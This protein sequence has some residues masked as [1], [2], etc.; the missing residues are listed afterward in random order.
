MGNSAKGAATILTV[1]G[2][3]SSSTFG[4]AI[5]DLWP[6]NHSAT[7]GLT[8]AGS[9]TLVLTGSSSFS[10]PTV[11][12]NGTLRLNGGMYGF[13]GN[14]SGWTLNDS[15]GGNPVTIAGNV[16]TLTTAD[17]SEANAMWYNTPLPVVGSPWTATFTYTNL[18][19]NGA[20]GGA[21]VLQTSGT[22]ALGND[23][24]AKGLNGTNGLYSPLTNSAAIVWNIYSGNGG[25]KVN[26][27]TGGNASP[28]TATGNGVNLDSTAPVNITLAYNGTSA[29]YLTAVQGAN[30]W[31]QT[32]SVALGS[33]LNNPVNGTAY[34]GFVG[35]TGGVDAQ[36]QISNFSFT[37]NGSLGSVLSATSPVQLAA[38]AVLDLNGGYQPVGSL[39]GG[40]TLTNSNAALAATVAVGGDNTS[41]TF[42][43][44]LT[45]AVPGNLALAKIGSGTQTLSGSN[46][47]AG[48]TTVGGGVLRMGNSQALGPAGGSLTISGGT[49]DMNGNSL[50]VS[51]LG[52]I[53]G[54][55]SSSSG[56]A[57]VLTANQASG[58]GT[59]GGVLANGGGTLGFTKTG[60]GMLLL[61]GYNSYSGPTLVSGGTLR[62]YNGASGFGGNGSGWNVNDSTGGYPVSV[63]GDAATLTTANNS[64]ANAIWLDRPLA[65]V[66]GPW[67]AKFTYTNLSGDG[68][69]GGAFVLQTNG[70]G[71]LGN[72]GGAKGLNGTNGSYSTLT[73]SA[74]IVWNIYSGNGGSELSYLTGGNATPTTSTTSSGVNLDAM[75]PVNFTLSYNG[76]SALYLTAVQGSSSWTQTYSVALGTALNNPANGLAYVGFVG[77]T[78]GVNADQQISN[79][80]FSSN[81]GNILPAAS[82]VQLAAGAVL[83]VN[84]QNQTIGSLHGAGLLTNSNTSQVATLVAGDDNSSQ[85]FSGSINSAVPANLALIKIGSGSQTLG[86]VDTFT[87]PATVQGGVLRLRAAGAMHGAVAVTAGTLDAGGFAQT[88]QSLLMSAGGAWTC[89]LAIC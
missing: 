40:G 4:G 23:G 42:S 14:G 13:G 18:T 77:G 75:T 15:T 80:S 17:A 53:Y 29:L 69:D 56:T 21:F 64:E 72:N 84:G 74:A 73:H 59:Y 11:V 43:G 58:I 68:A 79:F 48:G 25:S 19:G 37:G 50:T 33:A 9:G 62:L 30:S 2:D 78:G 63:S 24:G 70:L 7:G 8:K 65:V 41:Q 20:D 44:V 89:Q 60:G 66:G 86:G 34:V 67:T 51:P 47:F 27:L 16:A 85:T 6:V 88:I 39:S 54:A 81:F 52:G 26:Y 22:N 87:G 57:A 5:S 32:Y 45:S 35:G 36:Q 76:T 71:A 82:P 38:G 31:S 46:N 1:G 10:G 28:S 49:L 83:D 55:I 12:S 61:S 3:N